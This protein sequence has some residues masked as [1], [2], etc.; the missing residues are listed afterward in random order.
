[1][2][3]EIIVP[4]DV[5]AMIAL[6]FDQAT[7]AQLLKLDFKQDEFDKLWHLGLFESINK[8]AGTLIDLAEDDNITDLNK[9]NEILESSL[10]DKVQYSSELAPIVDQMRRLFIEAREK[11]TGVFFYF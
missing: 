2:K 6:D 4:K 8:I 3:R 5:E 9:L 7:D 11:K 1:M 10:L